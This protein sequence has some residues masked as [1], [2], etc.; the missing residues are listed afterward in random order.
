MSY[1][2]CTSRKKQHV[3]SPALFLLRI[4]LLDV[5]RRSY[6]LFPIPNYPVVQNF[7]EC[8]SYCRRTVMPLQLLEYVPSCFLNTFTTIPSLDFGDYSFFYTQSHSS[9]IISTTPF[10]PIFIH[11]FTIPLSPA[12]LWLCGLVILFSISSMVKSHCS[13]LVPLLCL[14][15]QGAPSSLNDFSNAVFSEG[16]SGPL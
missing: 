4:I 10:P 11:S 7:A 1:A 9:T 12:A 14:L 8:L 13:S 2:F 6:L 15:I 16:I 5:Y 3:F